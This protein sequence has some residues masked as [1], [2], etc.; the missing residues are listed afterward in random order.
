MQDKVSS[1]KP[2]TS[3]GSLDSLEFSCKSS[4]LEK[5]IMKPRFSWSFLLFLFTTIKQS[6]KHGKIQPTS[7]SNDCSCCFAISFNHASCSCLG[8]NPRSA[9]TK[10]NK[11]QDFVE[12]FDAWLDWIFN[13]RRRCLTRLEYLQLLYQLVSIDIKKELRDSRDTERRYWEIERQKREYSIFVQ[14]R[15]ML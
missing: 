13:Q 8:L 14:L 7:F 9:K 10:K 5:S 12:V 3:K 1:S 11:K 6:S 4:F 2:Y 15:S